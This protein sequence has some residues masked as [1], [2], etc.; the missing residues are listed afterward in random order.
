MNRAGFRA[1]G[2]LGTRYRAPGSEAGRKR[3][4]RLEV[5]EGS[6]PIGARSSSVESVPGERG[7]LHRLL[8]APIANAKLRQTTSP[9]PSQAPRGTFISY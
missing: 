4:E 5:G 6:A 8:Q 2:Q 9:K 7:P 3:G 1:E